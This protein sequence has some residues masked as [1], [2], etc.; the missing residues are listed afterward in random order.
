M[1]INDIPKAWRSA[2]AS[3]QV[4]YP[5][6]VIA[7]GCLRDREEG[8]KVKDIDIFIPSATTDRD[9]GRR[10][11]NR[12]KADGWLDLQVINDKTYNGERISM[13]METKFPGCPVLNI[14]VGPYDLKEFDF[15]IC[16]IEFNGKRIHRTRD[17]NLDRAEKQ[18]RLIPAVP[19]SEF[20]RSLARWHRLKEKYPTWKLHLGSRAVTHPYVAP[21]MVFPEYRDHF[22]VTSMEQARHRSVFHSGGTI[23]FGSPMTAPIDYLLR[24]RASEF[25]IPK[26]LAER[27]SRELPRSVVK[28]HRNAVDKFEVEVH[29][30]E[31]A[32]AASLIQDT[33]DRISDQN[34]TVA[35]RGTSVLGQ[36]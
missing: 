10:V 12:L 26:G 13:A 16:Q 28:P 8:V 6:A 14:V 20:I 30:D 29:P 21:K 2:L 24:T 18:F 1:E 9:E 22:G 15:G 35:L 31:I 32:Q 4:S 7:G 19:D 25:V 11:L 33:V 34:R 5:D 17:Y 27:M 3:V 36:P 23:D